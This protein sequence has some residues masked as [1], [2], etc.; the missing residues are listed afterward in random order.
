MRHTTDTIYSNSLGKVSDFVFD[1]KIARVFPDMIRRSVP[2]YNMIIPSISLISARY[3]QTGSHLYDLGCSLGAATLAMRQ[4]IQKEDCQ[5]IGIDNSEAMLDRC[6][7]YI[8]LDNSPTPVTLKLG[9]ICQES[10]TNASMVTLNF[11]LQFITPEKRQSLLNNI[12]QGMNK[13]GVLVLSEKLVF[14]QEEQHVLEPLQLDFKRANGYSE[15]EISQKRNA[16]ANVM[17]PETLQVHQQRLKEAGFSQSML[18][19]QHFNFASIIAIK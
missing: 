5:I 7:N 3:A 1:E 18:W 19:L 14:N 8:N 13:G 6:Q 9:D 4:G 11:T 17:I 16:I 15:L 10:I 12:C 2:G